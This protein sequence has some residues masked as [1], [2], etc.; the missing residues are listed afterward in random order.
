MSDDHKDVLIAAYLF[1]DLAKRD[2]VCSATRRAPARIFSKS[3]LASPWPCVT[4]QN[5]WAPAASAACACSRICSGS[6]IGCI[7][8]SASA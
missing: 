5:R 7:G 4:M 2:F 1:E 6:I 3:R 8:V